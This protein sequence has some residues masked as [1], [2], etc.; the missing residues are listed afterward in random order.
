MSNES[1]LHRFIYL[2]IFY[3]HRSLARKRVLLDTKCDN[4]GSVWHERRAVMDSL[5][6]YGAASDL[7]ELHCAARIETRSRLDYLPSIYGSG[8]VRTFVVRSARIDP[9]LGRLLF[10]QSAVTRQKTKTFSAGAGRE[11]P[12]PVYEMLSND[13][14]AQIRR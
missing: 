4:E 3:F 6:Q 2:L 10:A 9:L 14:A 13:G 1:S 7:R 12:L 5:R 8:S 11:R